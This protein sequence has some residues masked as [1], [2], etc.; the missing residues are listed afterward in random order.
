MIK[1][2]PLSSWIRNMEYFH[3]LHGWWETQ[4]LS[5]PWLTGIVVNHGLD[6]I[7]IQEFFSYQKHQSELFEQPYLRNHHWT[8]STLFEFSVLSSDWHPNI[9]I[10][11]YWR[12]RMNAM[13]FDSKFMESELRHGSAFHTE[14]AQLILVCGIEDKT[15][16]KRSRC[17][18]LII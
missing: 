11:L 5:C 8:H 12:F 17:A 6:H 16:N 2:N 9:L 4:T 1:F 18:K 7:N 10:S 3:E 15:W 14:S 13:H